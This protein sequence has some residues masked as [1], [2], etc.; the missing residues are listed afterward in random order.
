M[1]HRGQG[2]R[3]AKENAAPTIEIPPMP[4]MKQEHRSPDQRL[5]VSLRLGIVYD[6]APEG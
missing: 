2:A 1:G 6:A 5:L 4:R 3:L